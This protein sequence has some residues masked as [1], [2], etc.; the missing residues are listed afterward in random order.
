MWKI[1]RWT[2]RAEYVQ[3]L[4]GELRFH[5]DEL[6]DEYEENGLEPGEARRRA[7][8]KLGNP[9]RIREEVRETSWTRWV[10]DLFRDLRFA[11]RSLRR[12]G[13]VTVVAIAALALGIGFS[14]TAF[15]V[16]YNGVLRPFPY[17]AADRQVSIE[18]GD[19]KSG[20]EDRQHMFPLE[21]VAAFRQD[22]RDFED[23]AGYSVWYMR[24]LHDGGAEMV[25]G[26]VLTPNAIEFF[27]M[28]PVLG[29]SL[30]PADSQPTAAPVVVLSYRFWKE[31]FQGD[32]A[33]L[34]KTLELSGRQRTVVG[35]MPLRF[36]LMGSD[37]YLPVAWQTSQ[38]KDEDEPDYYFANAILRRG[39]SHEAASAGLNVI[40]QQLKRQKP[41]DFPPNAVA[42][43]RDWSDALYATFKTM[44]YLLAAA[45]ALLLV[46]SCSNAAGLLLVHASS[47][48]REMAVRRALGAGRH[49]L[50]R[51]FLAESLVL[52]SVG[53]LLGCLLATCA[54]QMVGKGYLAQGVFCG[55]ADV[56]MNWPTLVLAACVSF[57]ATVA[58]GVAPAVISLRGDIQK[59]LGSNGAGVHASFRGGG[60]RS[61]LVIGQV[62]LSVVLL[63]AAGLVTR[64][65]LA[66]MHVN[67]GIQASNLMFAWSP[68]PKGKYKTAEERTQYIDR[69]MDRLEAV[70]G[71]V[72]A[73]EATHES[74]RP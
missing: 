69:L 1:F 58:A 35:V 7:L 50:L 20:E 37:L 15:S 26:G 4:E 21:E 65:F 8:L 59:Q 19:P 29:R 27:G 10:T 24:Y 12:A 16:V 5:V 52:A 13:H 61:A 48:Q 22:T 9:Q 28:Q 53:C 25:H 39:V 74:T 44:F 51:Q 57:V 56:R 34:G 11:V 32:P 33:V 40:L 38:L 49:R 31:H 47:R 73:T 55:E 41:K 36:A 45:V 54:V 18:A 3:E 60:F 2:R 62:A 42:F 23:V 67:Y 68:F 66:M 17:R 72:S 70:P 64:T 63:V 43:A 46:I 14:A 71:V 6:T 30:T